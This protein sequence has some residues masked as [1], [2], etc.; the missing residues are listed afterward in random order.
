MS[1]LSV[2]AFETHNDEEASEWT[3][4][5]YSEAEEYAKRYGYSIIEREYEYSDSSLVADYRRGH[6][7]MGFPVDGHDCDE[8][9][10]PEFTVEVIRNANQ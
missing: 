5:V 6:D 1:T 9:G 2:Y 10:A 3:T 8:Y 7:S 4:M